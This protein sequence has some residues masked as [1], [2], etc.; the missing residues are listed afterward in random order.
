MRHSR[1]ISVQGGG[2]EVDVEDEDVNYEAMAMADGFHSPMPDT[3]TAQT[4]IPSPYPR[5]ATLATEN[6]PDTASSTGFPESTDVAGTQTRQPRI[7]SGQQRPSSIAKPPTASQDVPS[8]QHTGGIPRLLDDPGMSRV[9]SASSDSQPFVRSEGPYQGPSGPSHP[10]GVY[11][12]NAGLT[13]TLSVATS[14]TTPMP[15]SAFASAPGPMHPYGMYMQGTIDEITSD[16]VAIPVG[17][18]G[19]ANQYQHAPGSTGDEI[20]DIVGPDGH[21]EQLPPYSR[22]P[23]SSSAYGSE[24]AAGKAREA[25]QLSP[26]PAVS[27][28]RPLA[29]AAVVAHD[30]AAASGS[31]AAPP[32]TI[33]GAGGLGLATRNPEY[34]S[35]DEPGSP[36]SRH[37]SRS[38]ATDA[39]QHK[40][41]TAAAG[42]AMSEKDKPLTRWQVWGRRK[43]CGVFP[44][45]ALLLAITVVLLVAGIVIGGVVGTQMRD[46]HN[47]SPPRKGGS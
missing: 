42:T 25:A 23:P 13:R 7:P 6:R 32:P 11:T 41:N 18:A 37:S 4:H 46:S 35:T 16:P 39:S 12:Q 2:E 40:I 8:S 14:S 9:S 21:T 27:T 26:S 47:G 24:A 19:R 1:R 38:F 30:A 28:S 44:Y 43:C 31:V 22:E 33:S 5:C 3:T 10:Y 36:R 20:A 34:E 15:E 29:G 45:W 17:F